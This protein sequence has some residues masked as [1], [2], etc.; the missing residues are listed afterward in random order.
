MDPPPLSKS[1]TFL[2][3]NIT[4]LPNGR[5]GYMLFEKALN[6]EICTSQRHPVILAGY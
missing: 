1:A 5:P 6:L 2:D 4:L 3:L